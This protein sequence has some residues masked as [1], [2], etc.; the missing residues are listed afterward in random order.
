M[1]IGNVLSFHADKISFI[2]V[3]DPLPSAFIPK[4]PKEI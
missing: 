2:H 4:Y 3:P 1:F